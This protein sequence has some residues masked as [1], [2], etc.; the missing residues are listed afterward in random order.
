MKKPRWHKTFLGAR[1]QHTY[2]L[3]KVIDDILV[4]NPQIL[5]FVEI[6]TGQGALSIV[7]GLHAAKRNTSLLTF[8]TNNRH[9]KVAM[10]FPL[11]NI[12]YH[13]LNCFSLETKGI[14][15]SHMV[16]PTFFFCDGDSKPKEFSTFVPMLPPNSVVAVHDYSV[17]IKD[18]DME[19]TVKEYNLE[20]LYKE[21]WVG[22]VD[23]IQTCFFLKP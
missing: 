19:D 22:G 1:Q 10:L 12:V 23:D 13:E 7:L 5:K 11:L 14:L 18:S 6:G 2:W 3:Y 20:P 17:E 8:D 9:P 16:A 15:I 4:N 21:E